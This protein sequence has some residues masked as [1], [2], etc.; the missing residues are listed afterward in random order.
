MDCHQI[1]TKSGAK[2][3][4]TMQIRKKE[5]IDGWQR[6]LVGFSIS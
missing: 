5:I 6:D 1:V 2:W 4:K 3:S